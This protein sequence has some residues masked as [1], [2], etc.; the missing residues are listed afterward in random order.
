[1]SPDVRGTKRQRSTEQSPNNSSRP[2]LNVWGQ[3]PPTNYNF[4][5]NQAPPLPVD[6]P[7]Y[8]QVS[9]GELRPR[10]DGEW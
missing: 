2:I 1:M 3:N 5:Y 4:Y 6:P 7:K 9:C 10:D 8:I